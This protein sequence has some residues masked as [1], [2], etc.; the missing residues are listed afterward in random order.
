MERIKKRHRF[1]EWD[2]DRIRQWL[3][4]IPTLPRRAPRVFGLARLSTLLSVI[5]SRCER[6]S[7]PTPSPSAEDR[8]TLAIQQRVTQLHL[9][10]LHDLRARVLREHREWLMRAPR[11]PG[12]SRRPTIDNV[13]SAL[14]RL[15]YGR[16]LRLIERHLKE[17]EKAAIANP[18]AAIPN[19][20]SVA[21]VEPF[22]EGA[23]SNVFMGYYGPA[24]PNIS[25]QWVPDQFLQEFCRFWNIGNHTHT[26][27]LYSFEQLS[28]DVIGDAYTGCISC[29]LFR[30]PDLPPPVDYEALTCEQFDELIDDFY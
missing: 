23:N 5:R 17:A 2:K 12:L 15:E 30:R 21:P 25:G 16:A 10:E 24:N 3:K 22:R 7:L 20:E 6:E 27:E 28:A 19:A 14:R 18:I 8:I 13:A 26:G 4:D 9:E 11:T 1:S 29:D